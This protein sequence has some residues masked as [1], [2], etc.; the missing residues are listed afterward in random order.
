MDE[1]DDEK[2]ESSHL[3]PPPLESKKESNG[4]HD[5]PTAR[6]CEQSLQR[7]YSSSTVHTAP[8][9]QHLALLMREQDAELLESIHFATAND[10]GETPLITPAAAPH[11]NLP[12]TLSLDGKNLEPLCFQKFHPPPGEIALNRSNSSSSFRLSTKRSSKRI[13]PSI[14]N[15]DQQQE[16]QQQQKLLLSEDVDPF[17]ESTTTNVDTIWNR[18][19][20]SGEVWDK[21]NTQLDSAPQQSQEDLQQQQ[22]FLVMRRTGSTDRRMNE[23]AQF[24]QA[25]GDFC[26][27]D[28]LCI[29]EDDIHDDTDDDED[30]ADNTVVCMED[31]ADTVDPIVIVPVIVEPP[32]DVRRKSRPQ[33]PFGSAT[34]RGFL[35]K[36]PDDGNNL[37]HD[38]VYKGILSNPPVMVKR[39]TDRGN[40]AQLHRKAWLEVS[41]KYHR[42]GKHLRFYYRYWE[43]LGCPTNMFFDWLDSKGEAAGQPLPTLDECPRVELD[44]DTVLYIS[45]DEV[46][47]G[48]AI[49]FIPEKETGR[50]MVVDVDGDPVTTGPDGWIFVLRDNV[51]YGAKKITSVSGKQK[52]RFHHSSFFG[53]K[54]VA[55]AG[56]IITDENGFLTRLYP[57]SGHYR[58]G[59]AHMQRMLFFLNS[60]GVDLRTLDMD[61]QQMLHVA[62]D[63]PASKKCSE[64]IHHDGAAEKIEKKKKVESL[65]LVPAVLVACYLAHKARFIGAG[66]FSQL[67]GI[68]KS[69]ATTVREALEAID[70]TGYN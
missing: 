66:I 59:E 36:L 21:S 13:E 40:Y 51:M 33:W 11:E 31:N 28:D 5:A 4:L 54:A 64:T 49:R 10:S 65:C 68:R 52:Q 37:S 18:R 30:N 8:S 67:H 56:I 38:F 44:F 60:A 69:G 19:A 35:D 16:Q 22:P 62:R 2:N 20:L 57:H 70:D 63:T 27:Q 23:A 29:I 24:A 53:G 55:A 12:P 15:I 1:Q 25:V 61:M 32:I 34:K 46:T 7:H 50:G 48:Y 14:A 43:R 9:M 41:D 39:G 58:P 26:E 47:Q 42:Y 45:N 3:H 17:D 6:T